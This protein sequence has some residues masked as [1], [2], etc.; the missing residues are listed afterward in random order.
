MRR[1]IE[2]HPAAVAEAEAARDWY[3]QRSPIAARAFLSALLQAVDKVAAQPE[4]WPRFSE[5]ARRYVLPRFPFSLIYRVTQR[6]IH[7][8]A[9]AHNKRK[10]GY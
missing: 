5:G 6:A 1:M 2:F 8:I 10:P 9:L 7:I 4:R 3:A